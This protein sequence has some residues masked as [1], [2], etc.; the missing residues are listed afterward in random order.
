MPRV[1]ATTDLLAP[2]QP[3]APPEPVAP[4]PAAFSA[5]ARELERTGAQIMAATRPLVGI[6]VD[7]Q[8]RVAEAEVREADTELAARVRRR[9]REIGP[10]ERPGYLNRR[11]RDALDTREE[12]ERGLKDDVT[13][14]AQR[15][16]NKPL[17][18]ELFERVASSRL[19]NAYNQIDAHA[20]AEG[21]RYAAE[22]IEA[23]VVSLMQDAMDETD[24]EKRAV[25]LG[26][27][28]SEADKVADLTGQDKEKLRL[29][30]TTDFHT[31][32]ADRISTTD[33]EGAQNY[34]DAHRSQMDRQ[35]Y[36][37]LSQS[38]RPRVLAHRAERLAWRA[39]GVENA[40][41]KQ[42]PRIDD[43]ATRIAAIE[44]MN[45]TDNEL[46]NAAIAMVRQQVALDEQL[47]KQREE[48]ANRQVWEMI[49]RGRTPPAS[50][51][52]LASPGT[53][54]Q[55]RN[56]LT[57]TAAAQSD[58]Y[59][60]MGF[61]QKSDPVVSH[62]LKAQSASRRDSDRL[63]FMNLNLDQYRGQLTIKDYL[64]LRKAQDDIRNNREV[65]FANFPYDTIN[66]VVN[67]V[68]PQRITDKLTPRRRD[69]LKG[70]L[71]EALNWRTH[72]FIDAYRRRPTQAEIQNM[73]YELIERET[74]N[75][76]RRN[77]FN[78]PV[79]TEDFIFREVYRTRGAYRPE[80][81]Q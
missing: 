7:Q 44:R 25:L 1:P 8:R 45:I 32:I 67:R 18:R 55:V 15:F 59:R 47:F 19:E 69:E 6:L 64:D 27:I 38:L 5:G 62:T 79:M 81:G 71:L 66:T 11:G 56:L 34:L 60:A 4:S 37:N 73:A 28:L 48:V 35:V 12:T 53:R 54:T 72:E 29:K 63:T 10:D 39:R 68:F 3:A 23:R 58:P 36:E 74:F 13:E 30:Y 2:R 21:N 41:N 50:L 80:Q 20:F 77:W 52:A 9:L 16:R 31:A 33:P 26:V 61:A 17:Q 57:A 49:D 65:S 75:T 51:L 76:G 43:L 40:A 42:I 70:E 78:R 46:R 14:I 24:P 22:T